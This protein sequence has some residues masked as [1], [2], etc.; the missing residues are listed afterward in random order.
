MGEGRG[1]KSEQT[2]HNRFTIY[3]MSVL[4]T[5]NVSVEEWTLGWEEGLVGWGEEGLVGWG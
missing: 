1:G 4:Y 5:S 3:S 2:I